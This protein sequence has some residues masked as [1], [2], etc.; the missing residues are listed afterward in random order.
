MAGMTLSHDCFDP[1]PLA[2]GE[3]TLDDLLAEPIVQLF[4]ERDHVSDAEMR[5]QLDRL[6]R[7]DA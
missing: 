5:L 2:L 3:P 7:E 6:R 4:M 1:I